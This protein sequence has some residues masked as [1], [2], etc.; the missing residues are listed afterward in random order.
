MLL[1]I[2]VM[3]LL[4]LVSGPWCPEVLNWWVLL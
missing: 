3:M 2:M 4:G 1:L